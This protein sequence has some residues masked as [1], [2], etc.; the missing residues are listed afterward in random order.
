MCW[1]VRKTKAYKGNLQIKTWTKIT[2]N[3]QDLCQI[4]WDFELYIKNIIKHKCEGYQLHEIL[5]TNTS[6]KKYVEEIES[7]K[8]SWLTFGLTFSA[9]IF[10]RNLM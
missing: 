1:T 3:N 4:S 2:N 5:L 6:Q 8:N 9:G 10:E 7:S